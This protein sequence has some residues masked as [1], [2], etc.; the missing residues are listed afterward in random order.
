MNFITTLKRYSVLVILSFLFAQNVTGQ[1]IYQE[2]DIHRSPIRVFLNKFSFTLTTG[3][4][5]TSYSHD[6]SGVFFYQDSVNQ[7]VF[8]NDEN[9][10][11]TISGF[12]D[13]LNNPI[14]V[15]DSVS[16]PVVSPAILINTDTAALGFKGVSGGIPVTLNM[17][18]NFL[19]FR[20]GGGFTWE[21][22]FIRPLQPTTMQDQIRDYQPNFKATSYT[23]LY[24]LVGYRFYQFW[25]YDFVAELQ[26][27]KY[28]QGKQFN[29][30]AVSKGLVTNFG[31]SIE[32]N[33]SE[34]FRVIIKPSIDFRNH[35]V[36]LPDGSSIIHKNH[37]FLV[38]V[39]LSINI[40]EIPR[41]PMKSDHVQL[42]HIYTDPKTGRLKEVRGQPIWK[43]QNPKVGENHRRL[44]RY[45]FKNRRK[46]NP[47]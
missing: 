2:Y 40:P 35:T 47:Y 43:R 8:T 26:I 9:P 29:N 17:H 46:L 16:N 38:Q 39:G 30:A 14:P 37:T 10:G 44:W 23:R 1:S 32:N 25:T 4:S 19:N 28:G 22:Q 27:G 24:G 34:Y 5:R 20:I 3:Y 41:S 31:I 42:K 45:K 36:N 12:Q 21:R 6:L 7:F 18:Y 13:W 15:L 11:G 33:W